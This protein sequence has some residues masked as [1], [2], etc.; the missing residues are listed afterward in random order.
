MRDG[1]KVVALIPARGGSVSIPKKNI[2]PLLGR[3]LIDWVIRPALDS[4]VF[5]EVWV[6]TDCDQIAAVAK[7]CGAQ[8]HRRS[9][10]TATNTASTELAMLEFVRHHP[11]YDVLCLIQATS[12]L[13]TPTNFVEG[14]Q[15]MEAQ[16]ADSLV[17]GVRWH[18]FLWSVDKA[19][20]EATAKN[21]DPVKRPRR[22]DWNGELI[23]NG[24]FYFCTR[25]VMETHGCRLGGKMALYE[26]Q[27]HTLAELDSVIDWAFVAHLAADYGYIP[28]SCGFIRAADTALPTSFQDPKLGQGPVAAAPARA[29]RDWFVIG[30]A[31]AAG[32]GL[33]M[34]A[35][36]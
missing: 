32:A 27:E 22:Q 36:K 9:A 25:Q 24:A 20:G 19:T 26:M 1:K 6:S 2:K 18:R 21:Y 14:I 34:L 31:V 3:P 33:A 29:G 5:D 7:A 13:V 15:L 17:T 16:Q 28:D 23:E 11:V 12:P 8:V 10:E 30:C 35:C 4:G